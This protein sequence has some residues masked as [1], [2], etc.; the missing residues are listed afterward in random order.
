MVP[1]VSNS[2]HVYEYVCVSLKQNLFSQSF[3][4]YIFFVFKGKQA[5]LLIRVDWYDSFILFTQNI[6]P[7][8]HFSK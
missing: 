4:H 3:E 5:K 6:S 7:D 1:V 8:T 2:L